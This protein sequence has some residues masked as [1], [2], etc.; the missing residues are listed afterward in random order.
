MVEGIMSEVRASAVLD[1]RRAARPAKVLAMLSLTYPQFRRTAHAAFALA[2]A[3]IVA[4]CAGPARYVD[5]ATGPALP[6]F[7]PVVQE[8]M[9][10]VV[11]VSAIQRVSKAAAQGAE[12][13]SRSEERRVGKESRSRI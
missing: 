11:N 9:P 4:S 13:P 3:A 8:V 5:G 10:A 12:L 1:R 6:S 7:A 2:V